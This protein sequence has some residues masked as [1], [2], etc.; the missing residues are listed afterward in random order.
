M[1]L[2]QFGNDFRIRG[3][4]RTVQPLLLGT[5]AIEIV[6]EQSL[7]DDSLSRKI[8]ISSVLEILLLANQ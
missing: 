4:V 2:T 6:G 5:I 3:L 1:R 7:N 8:Q